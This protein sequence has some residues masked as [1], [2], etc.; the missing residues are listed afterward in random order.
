MKQTY[1]AGILAGIMALG[2]STVC[3]ASGIHKLV[4]E[5]GRIIFTNNAAKGS[6]AMQ[7]GK[8]G[9]VNTIRRANSNSG[10]TP[11]PI[12]G[13]YPR[14]SKL[15]QDQRDTKRRQILSQELT[16]ETRL[17]E[18][19][20]KTINLTLRETKNQLPNHPYFTSNHFDILQLRNQAASHERNIKALKAELNN[21]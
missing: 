3:I 19:A 4:D 5:H 10:V 13:N 20:L 2:S 11:T 12:T 21:L 8:A 7:S 1:C 18:D 6:V 14:V 16:N 15:Q 9:S 17:L